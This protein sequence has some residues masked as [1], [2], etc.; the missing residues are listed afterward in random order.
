MHRRAFQLFFS[1]SDL[2]EYLRSP[3]AT[4][5][6]RYALD[7]PEARPAADA[8][9]PASL[10]GYGEL[11]KRRGFE[12][13]ARVLE[14]LRGEGR[15]VLALEPHDPKGPAH[16][17]EAMQAGY[18]L[19]YQAHLEA[20]PFAGI[21][22]FLVR[23]PGASR[24]GDF[25]Y[26]VWDAKL[27]RRARPSHWLQLCCYADLLEA[28]QG[29][30]PAELRVELGDGSHET[31]RSE[32]VFAFYRALRAS[33]EAFLAGWTPDGAPLP[34]PAADHGRWQ[35]EAERRLAA[36]D[37]VS[38]V[39][40]CTAAQQRR[41]AAAGIET[42]TGLAGATRARVPGIDERT[43]ARLREQARLQRD[44]AAAPPPPRHR[45]LAPGEGEAGRGLALL[46]P[47]SPGDVAFDLEGD[48]LEQDGLEYLWGV[49]Y[50]GEDGMP[51]YHAWWAHDAAA[52]QRAFASFLDWL[53]ERRRR[54]PDLRVYHY[55]GYE[56]AVLRR[57]AGRYAVREEA[58]D[59][60]LRGQ[61]F[62]DLYALVR[63]GVRI[64]EPRYSLKNVERL[65]RAP[66]AGAV[67]GGMESVVV[68]D[69]WRQAGEPADP[70]ASPLLRRI[71]DYNE[72]DCRSTFE[73]AGWLR[74]QAGAAGIGFQPLGRREQDE[75]PPSEAREARRGRRALAE[76]MLARIPASEAERAADGERWGVQEL[77]AQLLEFHHREA[78]PAWWELFELAGLREDE[79]FEQ[80]ACLAGLQRTPRPPFALQQSL[81]FEYA[82]DPA[83]DSRI[84]AGDGGRLAQCL[85]AQVSVAELDERAGRIVLK[86][87]PDK[88]AKAGLAA[89]PER[90]C[91]IRFDYR[92]TEVIEEAIGTLA[93]RFHAS[94]DLPPALRDL[95]LRRPPQI[96]GHE[97]GAPVRRAGEPLAGAFLRAARGLD[98]SLLCVQ[99]PPGSGKT[100][101]SARV[102]LALLD[103]GR[104][105]GIT[106]HSHRAI[107]NL[108]EA[109]AREAGGALA[110]LKVGGDSP[111]DV[112]RFAGARHLASSSGVAA[113][114][115]TTP[116]VGATAWCFSRAD[117]AGRLDYLF[118]DEASQVSLANL[119]GMSRAARNLVLVGDQLQLSQ[120]TRGVH[121]GASG[122][123]ALDYALAGETIVPAE[124]GLFLERTHR[125]RPE[126]CAYVSQAFYAGRLEPDA[127]NA[128]RRLGPPP[129][130][131]RAGRLAAV[132]G[133]L[134][135]VPV[136]HQGN[137]QG[138]D[139]EAAVVA[140]LACELLGR[141]FTDHDGRT[142]P[143]GPDDLLVVAPYNL[144]VRK[145]EA[146]LPA[147]VR[148]G[149]VDRFQGQQAPVVLVSMCASEAQLS[150]RGIR[151]LFD[152]SRLN[153][154]VSRAQC[155][156]VVVGEPRLAT[157]A[158]RSVD[159]MKLVDRMCRLLQT[160][161][162]C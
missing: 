116:L 114:L 17:R 64:G 160:A 153:V 28:V 68:Y 110:C 8:G 136:A 118:V 69:A 135:F 63:H 137:T 112:P 7:H 13:E 42:L 119:V 52:E 22:D 82:F 41:L 5:M 79:R 43:F 70:G 71:R 85:D 133:G 97:C 96:R 156:A 94:G 134:V 95:L 33:F 57:L 48:P 49:V 90:V 19:I 62:V 148:V 105:V 58:L 1:P 151:F 74:G 99:G 157:A 146:A 6:S 76:R 46:P 35:E 56:V 144:Q 101:E 53:V 122:L 83:Q 26:T 121:P 139:E 100:T 61:V 10:P 32:E 47:A 92:G 20:A 14:R 111:G 34:D 152:P 107:V 149:T 65:Y 59:E 162:R 115:A 93:E 78:R 127:G 142:R 60:L 73:L 128:G 45:V 25:H 16:T 140:G 159:E 155:L 120:P 44:S 143:L 124:R 138:S 11:L 37:H 109:C 84:A 31:L 130:A 87:S 125:L 27:A 129:P 75:R 106:S 21:A 39:A 2:S 15:Q 150:A 55:G 91:L 103:A 24:L 131:A 50:R 123:S 132:G 67:Q 51:A 18:E 98:G 113:S 154:A 54:F 89:L 36:C 77:L 117:L 158:C 81:G 30:R 145:L 108:M 88:L 3:F 80:L 23:V 147:G 12:H 38:L 86:I 126:I 102:I 141:P 66:R 4:W 9:D 72:E 104:T 161:Q 29:V 40:G